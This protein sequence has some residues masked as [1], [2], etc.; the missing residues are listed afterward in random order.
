ME[1]GG[2]PD[3]PPPRLALGPQPSLRGWRGGGPSPTPGALSPSH[4]GSGGGAGGPSQAPALRYFQLP[5]RA[6]SAA[7]YV[8]ARSGR[9]R[10][11]PLVKQTKVVEGE[12]QKGGGLPPAPSPT[13]PASPQPPP[14]PPPAA[15]AP[16]EKNSIPIP[17]III[18]APSTSSSGRSSQG[19][20][21]EAEPPSQPEAA[22]GGVG[23]GGSSAPSPAPAVS[24]VPPSP[25]PVPTPA[26]PSGPATLDFTS[27]FGAALVGA[28]RREG[29]WQNEARRRSTLFLSTDAGDEDGGDS[30]L[31]PGAPP[32]P[33]LRHSKSIDEGMFSAEPYLRLESA[34][35]GSGYAGYAAGGRAYGGSSAFTSFLPP[36]PLVHPLTGKAL[37]PASPLGLAL[38]ARERALKESSEGGGPPQPPPRPPSPRYEAPPPTPHHHSPHAHH[39]PVLRLWGASPPDPARREL[40]YRAGLGSQEKSLPASPP[41]ARRSLLHRLPPTA[42][43]V[44]PLLLQLGPEPPAPHPGVSKPWRSGAPPEEPERLPL[45]VRFLENCQPRAGGAGGRGPPSEDGPGVPPP[46]PR[47]SVPPSPTS[48]RAQYPL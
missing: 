18:K 46:S 45:H 21:T 47:R 34:G 23:G 15:A 14:P 32:G 42:P 29:G 30:S 9:G 10:K 31:G 17:T 41:A 35:A 12:P 44:G 7:M 4:H 26:S 1:T 48:P 39:E 19:S 6:A 3:D 43:G 13:S 11:G 40:G 28:A 16:S 33:R 37:D 24:P 5:P 25:S 2:S 8:P 38:A 36:R 20:S 22:G 27:Q